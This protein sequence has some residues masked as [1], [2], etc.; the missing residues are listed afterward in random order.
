MLLAVA[1]RAILTYAIPLEHT[2]IIL[3]IVLAA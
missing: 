1:S 2:L 3:L